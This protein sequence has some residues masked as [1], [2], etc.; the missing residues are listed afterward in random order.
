MSSPQ[1]FEHE[2]YKKR[3]DLVINEIEQKSKKNDLVCRAGWISVSRLSFDTEKVRKFL[4][5]DINKYTDVLYN[6][7]FNH[8]L[9]TWR[10]KDIHYN[11]DSYDGFLEF[12]FDHARFYYHNHYLSMVW[13]ESEKYEYEHFEE[14]SEAVYK[15]FLK[16]VRH[17]YFGW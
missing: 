4:P 3:F 9:F 16:L 8:R 1:R 14:F 2:E 17:N 6:D 12:T 15:K 13:L 11:I 10:G 5:Q 7:W